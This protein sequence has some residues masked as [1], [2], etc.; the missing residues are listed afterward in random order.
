M[1]GY[2]TDSLTTLAVA[3]Q[4]TSVTDGQT[5]GRRTT[6]NTARLA[7]NAVITTATSI[8]RP[9]DG[10]MIAYQKSLRSQ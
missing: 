5:D 2:K 8:V 9:F 10:H 4:Y 7:F 3:I 1:M 6:A